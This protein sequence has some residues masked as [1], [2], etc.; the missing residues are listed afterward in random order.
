MVDKE[1]PVD[2]VDVYKQIEANMDIRD[3]DHYTESDPAISVSNWHNLPD[4][5]FNAIMMMV[6]IPDLRKCLQVCRFWKEK[7]IKNILENRTK[8]NIIRARVERVFGPG[9]FPS[10]E[11][12]RNVKW[13]GKYDLLL[14]FIKNCLF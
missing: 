13:L 2:I 14:I 7:I 3:Q 9:M 1:L 6:N 11:E 4:L 5:A 10:A 12:I 8:K